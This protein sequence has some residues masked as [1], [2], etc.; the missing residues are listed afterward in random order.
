MPKQ[1][2]NVRYSLYKKM[3]V[4]YSLGSFF[5]HLY[6]SHRPS[7]KHNQTDVSDFQYLIL[8]F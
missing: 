2:V 4:L 1:L 5:F 7:D 3:K 6:G 8:T